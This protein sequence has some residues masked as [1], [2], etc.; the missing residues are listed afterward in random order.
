MSPN[1]KLLRRAAMLSSAPD[2]RAAAHAAVPAGWREREYLS[3]TEAAAASGLSRAT[4]YNLHHRGLLLL[5]H[6]A[7][8][9]VIRPC[10]LL[11]TLHTAEEVWSP[12]KH[13]GRG[14]AARAARL[15]GKQRIDAA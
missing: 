7:G 14:A 8:R 3:L 9:T 1:P 2:G 6:V 13:G 5:R 4:F 12:Q 10:D 15:A 11:A